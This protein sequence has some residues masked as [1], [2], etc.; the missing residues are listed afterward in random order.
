MTRAAPQR[1]EL[2]PQVADKVGRSPLSF[3]LS[4]QIFLRG[5]ALVYLAAF[6]SMASQS[7]GLIGRQGL[8]PVHDF[9]TAA[10][11]QT[12]YPA[13]HYPTLLWLN[14]SDAT[15]DAIC[16][17]GAFAA[18]LVALGLLQLPMLIAC[19][20][21]YLSLAVGGQAF[22]AD[23]PWDSLLLEAGF[24]AIFVAPWQFYLGLKRQAEP[25]QL[26][27]W[28]LWWLLFRLLFGS[29]LAKV[30]LGHG[31][32]RDA[33]ALKHYFLV[34]PLPIFTS[35][36]ASRLP[37]SLLTIATW[38][39][40]ISELVLPFAILLGRW[41]RRLVAVPLV[42]IQLL[43]AL[44]GNYG[45]MNLL[46]IVLCLSMLDDAAWRCLGN[47]LMAPCHWISGSR[48]NAKPAR[49]SPA[50]F[51]IDAAGPWR[52]PL[53]TIVLLA[54]VLVPL[55][56]VQLSAQT[57]WV[58]SWPLSVRKAVSAIAPFRV[59]NAYGLYGAMPTNR[60]EM[61]IEGSRDRVTW[62]PYEFKF[63]P[64]DITEAPAI[65]G[66]HMPRVDWLMY[67]LRWRNPQEQRWFTELLKGLL[68]GRPQIE[69]LLQN[70]PFQDEPPEYIRVRAFEYRYATAAQQGEGYWWQR[71]HIVDS[72]DTA[73]LPDRPQNK[74]PHQ[75]AS[76][77]ATRPATEPTTLPAE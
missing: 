27:L 37:T 42:L 67:S 39:I 20:V 56:I 54:L 60:I 2:N 28:L 53:T 17:G 58:S 74:S 75:A 51:E 12:S 16:L 62:R 43:I 52:W 59:V 9:L 77:P 50:E 49:K 1:S 13:H 46:T 7:V 36:Y 11:Q 33:S 4:R 76:R 26:A 65:A 72:I 18:T 47:M 45:W 3:R 68:E 23:T 6:L 14:D 10:R 69:A 73:W 15:I 48:N 64:G 31:V 19:F 22:F 70:S 30:A 5:L 8:L 40:L 41:G 63:K 57:P 29:G 34:Q 66:P 38:A 71:E 21:L 32:W 24:L 44:T 35:W 61:I 25:R 55:G